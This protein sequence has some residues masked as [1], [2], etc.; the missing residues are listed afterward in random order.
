[1]PQYAVSAETRWSHQFTIIADSP[2]EAARKAEQ[3]A[4]LKLRDRSVRPTAV[5]VVIHS[6]EQTT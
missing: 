2:E 6:T 3:F 4:R 1:V 5:E